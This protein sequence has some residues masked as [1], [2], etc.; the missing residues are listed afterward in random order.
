MAFIRVLELKH[1]KHFL[2]V[3]RM[4]APLEGIPKAQQA[5]CHIVVENTDPAEAAQI[6]QRYATLEE[7]EKSEHNRGFDYI[8]ETDENDK[9]IARYTRIIHPRRIITEQESQ[10]RKAQ[11]ASTRWKAHALDGWPEALTRDIEKAKAK[12]AAS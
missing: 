6:A 9:P 7:A 11:P 2:G 3:D 8:I 5:F 12:L 4:S 10:E 1:M